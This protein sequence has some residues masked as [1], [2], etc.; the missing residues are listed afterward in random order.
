MEE[1]PHHN[2]FKLSKNKEIHLMEHCDNSDEENSAIICYFQYGKKESET[3]YLIHSMMFHMLEEPTYDYLRTK[4]QLGYLVYS[5]Q[6][7][8]RS[9]LGGVFGIQSSKQSPEY[10][11]KQILNFIDHA[12]EL[13]DNLSDEDFVKG[14]NALLANRRQPEINLISVKYRMHAEITTHKYKFNRVQ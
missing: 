6:W 5:K 7:N 1:I 3:D 10:L 4:E 8:Y 12:Q 11:L 14:V 13:S 2:I 9:I